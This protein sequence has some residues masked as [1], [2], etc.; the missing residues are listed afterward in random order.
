MVADSVDDS[1]HGR[2]GFTLGN[3]VGNF[4]TSLLS[5]EHDARQSGGGSFCWF[6]SDNDFDDSYFE[7]LD[8]S[9]AGFGLGWSF[10][11]DFS[12]VEYFCEVQEWQ[13]M[14]L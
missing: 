13:E 3:S 8:G 1:T 7:L 4:R 14:N 5:E 11:R 10:G 12:V 2:S 9:S 6:Y